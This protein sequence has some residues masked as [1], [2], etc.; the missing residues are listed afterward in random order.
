MSRWMRILS[1]TKVYSKWVL[2][3]SRLKSLTSLAILDHKAV[4]MIDDDT[5]LNKLTGLTSLDLGGCDMTSEAQRALSN[6]TALTTLRLSGCR[7]VTSEGLRTVSG[8]TALTS[9]DLG[10][11][12][13]NTRCMPRCERPHGSHHPQARL[14]PQLD[15]EGAA[16]TEQ[17]NCAHQPRAQRLPQRD[18]R[19]AVR[20]GQPHR[21]HGPQPLLLRRHG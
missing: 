4:S 21:A 3:A 16:R 5:L 6:L 13:K 11:C 12:R 2:D 9:L 15:D 17:P 1:R 14:E 18:E 20:C 19:G 10:Y 8:L 7:S